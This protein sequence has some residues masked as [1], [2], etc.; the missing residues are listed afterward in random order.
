MVSSNSIS[1]S[2]FGTS[3]KTQEGLVKLINSIDEGFEQLELVFDEQGN[4]IDFLFL[5]VNP[6]YEKQTGLKATDIIGKRKKEVA[7]AS[8][9]N[10]YDHAICAAKT[11]KIV[12]D[13][14]YDSNVERYYET[15]FIP[16][17]SNQVIVLFRDITEHKR[18]DENL[19]RKQ[20]ELETILD[21]SPT[22]IFYK[23]RYGKIIQ[24]N[25]ALAESLK[26]PVERLLGKTV[27][28]LYSLDI[29]Q[30][31]AN[32]DHVVLESK[33]SKLGII[34][35][36]ESPTGIR[37][38]R[39]DKIPTFDENGGVTGLIGFSEDI[40]DRKKAEDAL[41]N[42][43]QSYREL[44]ESF[45]EAFIAIDW[46]INVIHWNKAAERITTVA[47]KDA[48]GKKVFEVLPEMNLV[49]V[50]P[51]LEALQ[52]KK[53]V[54]FMMNVV[55]RQTKQ[56][57]IFEISTYPSTQG[58]I[59]VV[60]D[61]T[62][63]ERTK[64]LSTIGQVAG[65]VGHDIRNPLQAIISE[66]FLARQAMVEAS[67]D[68]VAK[69]ALE[70]IDLVQEQVDYI[71]KIVSDLQDYARPLIPEYVDVDLTDLAVKVFETVAVPDN[72]KLK[73]DVKDNLRLKTD[74]TFV[75]RALTNLVNNAI[76][77]M[78]DG[79]ELG[80]TAH[81]Q[82]DCVVITVSDSGKGIPDSVK[83][84]L[85][86]PLM[87]TKSKGQGL[88]LAVVKRLVEGLS[89][90]VSYETEAGKGTKFTIELHLL[91]DEHR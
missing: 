38:L 74:V 68:K 37:W 12:K 1:N 23:D 10:W 89:G 53:P 84:N 28:D 8:D 79:G 67:K 54:R 82:E 13:Q 7:P 66:L 47:A 6:A 17:S 14:Y 76:Q 11:G 91:L 29:A 22:I 70:S 35:P 21:S 51:Y 30:A 45:D 43:E 41:R 44:Y 52:A 9:P 88:G 57:A 55:S 16:V 31:M 86:T 71:N 87:T 5:Q 81:K 34:E 63:E 50:G 19:L 46:E 78:P 27:F 40:T 69:E 77:A 65:M 48:L 64:R 25:R 36:Y 4:V 80:L 59:I 32:D 58:I 3:C 33:H 73:V 39:T 18:A 60:E 20:L 24:A 42:S 56:D 61:K 85:F 49:N 2:D 83:A 75:K 26:M 15:R 62:E 90:K 72:V